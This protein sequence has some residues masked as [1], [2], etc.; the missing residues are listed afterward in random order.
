MSLLSFS[1]FL[2]F[3][4]C[5]SLRRSDIL[6]SE[7]SMKLTI[8][9]SKT[10]QKRKGQSVIV[11]RTGKITCPVKALEN[12]LFLAEI[13][14]L[15]DCYLFRKV[16]FCKKSNKHVLRSGNHIAY[17]TARETLLKNLSEIGLSPSAFGL[18]SLRSGGATAAAK[19][20]MPDRLFKK[21]GRWKSDKAKDGYVKDEYDV[22][23]QVS[24]NLGI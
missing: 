15:S 24:K 12:Y 4:E 2:R 20:G 14:D 16:A 6:I 7:I 1:G 22:R 11:S 17:S 21:H 10:D 9:S 8:S 19:C 13:P 23:C 3:S 5:V 18:H